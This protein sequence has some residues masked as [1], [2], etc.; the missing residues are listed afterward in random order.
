MSRRSALSHRAVADL[1]VDAGFTDR[2]PADDLGMAHL[3]CRAVDRTEHKLGQVPGT[4]D[5][6]DEI[7][8]E[9][10]LLVGAREAAPVRTIHAGVH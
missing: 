10:R 7:R 8:F 2:L 6:F 9:H 4:P 1:L 5:D 3:I